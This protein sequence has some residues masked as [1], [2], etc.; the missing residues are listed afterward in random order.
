MAQSTAETSCFQ[1]DIASR[2]KE[3]IRKRRGCVFFANQSL[4][5]S[6]RFGF[7]FQHKEEAGA[8]RVRVTAYILRSEPK[9]FLW[10]KRLDRQ[11]WWEPKNEWMLFEEFLE[12]FGH[13][14]LWDMGEDTENPRGLRELLEN[15]TV[16][17]L[18][19]D[20]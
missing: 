1:Q 19:F 5:R 6:R 15:M 16:G 10:W 8:L 3:T 13:I 11:Y 2:K 18:D 20:D 12:E 14:G 17:R 7:I 4:D 9:R